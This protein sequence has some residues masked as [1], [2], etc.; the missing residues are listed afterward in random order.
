MHWRPVYEEWLPCWGF[1]DVSGTKNDRS[2]IIL[3]KFLTRFWHP[4]EPAVY[5]LRDPDGVC[6]T[7]VIDPCENRRW[8]RLGHA[9][10][11]TLAPFNFPLHELHVQRRYD[12]FKRHAGS[13]LR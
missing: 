1:D 10:G 3:A 4:N 7:L 9:Y 12:R 2:A 11:L 8:V 6:F 5:H 13:K